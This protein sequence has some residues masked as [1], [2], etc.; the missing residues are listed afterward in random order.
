MVTCISNSSLSRL[1]LPEAPGPGPA[2]SAGAWEGRGTRGPECWG[3]KRLAGHLASQ[4]LGAPPW[5]R[6]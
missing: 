5:N 3:W 6:R 2:G 4:D 1:L